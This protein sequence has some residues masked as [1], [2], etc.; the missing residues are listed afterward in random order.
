MLTFSAPWRLV[1]L[2]LLLL[3]Q[4]PSQLTSPGPMPCR[5]ACACLRLRGGKQGQSVK[6]DEQEDGSFVMKVLERND[7]ERM[8][9]S[10]SESKGRKEDN[11]FSDGVRGHSFLDVS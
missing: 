5:R 6:E 1:I 2:S 11:H 9:A 10:E 7:L 8:A 4:G 3:P